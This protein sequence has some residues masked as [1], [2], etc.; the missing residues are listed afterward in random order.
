[1]AIDP[2]SMKT[3]P[4]PLARVAEEQKRE[5][6]REHHAATDHRQVRVDIADSQRTVIRHAHTSGSG[7][8]K[9]EEHERSHIYTGD[10][11]TRS[12]RYGG[13]PADN[14]HDDGVDSRCEHWVC[15]RNAKFHSDH[16]QRREQRRHKD[17]HE[18][19]RKEP[20]YQKPLADSSL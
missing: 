10:A 8:G 11:I 16:A 15:S 20:Y 9:H 3:V 17:E 2:A 14:E 7:S 12:H 19:H 13:N 5:N 4:T 18:P 1:M 6:D